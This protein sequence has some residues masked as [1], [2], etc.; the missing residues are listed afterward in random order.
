MHNTDT[1]NGPIDLEQ[2]EAFSL[3]GFRTVRE[4]ENAKSVFAVEITGDLLQHKGILPGDV[5]I[6]KRSKNHQRGW[7]EVWDTPLGR[8]A[9]WGDMQHDGTIT[10]HN[11]GDSSYEFSLDE[12]RLLGQ[13]VRVERDLFKEVQYA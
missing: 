8:S 2:C 13:V 7:L 11:R 5:L 4:V 9:R 6:V 1:Y 3:K 12:I 10:L